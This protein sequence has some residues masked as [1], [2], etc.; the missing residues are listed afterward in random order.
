MPQET[1]L[2]IDDGTNITVAQLQCATCE[3]S[4]YLERGEKTVIKTV[5]GDMWEYPFTCP[6]CKTAVFVRVPYV[7]SV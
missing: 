7:E 2:Q 1:Q 6:V 3:T 5:A 4:P